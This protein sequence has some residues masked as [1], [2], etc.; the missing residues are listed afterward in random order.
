MSNGCEIDN[1]SD[2]GKKDCEEEVKDR[3]TMGKEDGVCDDQNSEESQNVHKKDVNKTPRDNDGNESNDSEINKE[4]EKENLECKDLKRSYVNIAKNSI[5]DNKLTC[6]PTETD[7]DGS[8]FVIFDEEIVKE[9]SKKWEFTFKDEMRVQSVIRNGPWM[10]NGKP[11]FVQKWDPTVCLDRAE[12]NKLPFWVKLRNLPLEAWSNKGL[13]DIASR[14][15]T[16]LIMDKVTTDMCKMGTG[17]VGF[18]RVLIE[19]EAD[20]G[21]P[22]SIDIL[23]KDGKNAVIGKKPRTVEEMEEMDKTKTR[24]NDGKDEFVP[25]NNRKKAENNANRKSNVIK[26]NEESSK[27]NGSMGEN[28]SPSNKSNTGWVVQQDII[29]SIRMSANKY[30]VLQDNDEGME[31]N[32]KDLQD[33]ES[34]VYEEIERSTSKDITVKF[35][36]DFKIATWNIRVLGK[37]L[38]QNAVRNLIVEERLEWNWSDNAHVMLCLVEVVSTKEKIY[39]CFIHAKNDRRL[40][41]SLWND[42]IRFKAMSNNSHMVLIGDLNVSLHLDDHSEGMSCITQDME[43]F[44]DCANSLRMEDVCNT[45]LHY[46]WTKSLLNPSSGVLK[47]IDRVMGSEKF[48]DTYNK[49]YVVFLPYGISDHS[50][51]VLTCSQILKTTPKSFR[52]ILIKDPH[53]AQLRDSGVKLLK[54]YIVAIEDEEKLLLQKAKVEWLNDGDRNSAYFH[55]VL[56]GR[57]NRNMVEAICRE[58]NTRYVGD[59]INDQDAMNMIKEISN[60]DI[61]DEMFVIDDNKAPGPDGFT[62]KFF[63]KSWNVVGDDVCKTIKECF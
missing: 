39:Y 35:L 37:A 3:H 56:K 43:E 55:K 5:L 38:K 27:T 14:L 58:D 31:V 49:S 10:V 52:V 9:G 11:M 25:L 60:E 4:P 41:R 1:G 45:G 63:K 22:D 12:P 44:Q 21:L 8:E 24:N 15:E 40:R 57:V 17:R 19:V 7:V 46:T 48:M 59:Q 23:H 54:E 18:A 50:P 26:D 30:S 36:M 47:K 13:S 34:D 16:P 61:K 6:I 42:L 20:K 2:I 51:A 33:E 29:D 62:T 32:E 28:S 53:N